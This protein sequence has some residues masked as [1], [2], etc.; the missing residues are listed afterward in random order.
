MIPK[1][2]IADIKKRYDINL[3]ARTLLNYEKDGFIPEAQRSG[4]GRGIGK[5][6]EYPPETVAEFIASYM[7]LHGDEFR[8]PP[9]RVAEIRKTAKKIENGIWTKEE[10][11]R[12]YSQNIDQ[13]FGAFFWLQY[14][15]KV[16]ANTS[17]SERVGVQH[18]LGVDGRFKREFNYPDEEGNIKMGLVW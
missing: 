9:A 11:D 7:L 18:V 15:A 8:L 3:T 5:I 12:L 4:G 17:F 1:E 10:V 13:F 6:T 14:K 16:E 2:V